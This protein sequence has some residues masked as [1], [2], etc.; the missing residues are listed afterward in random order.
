MGYLDKCQGGHRRR[1]G[2]APS[3]E[4]DWPVVPVRERWQALYLPDDTVQEHFAAFCSR[5]GTTGLVDAQLKWYVPVREQKAMK[6]DKEK[7]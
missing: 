4:H 2:K 7:A 6:R 5:S 3:T 1:S